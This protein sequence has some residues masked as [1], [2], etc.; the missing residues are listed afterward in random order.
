MCFSR[1]TQVDQETTI[2]VTHQVHRAQC[3]GSQVFPLWQKE[4]EQFRFQYNLIDLLTLLI[5][6]RQMN[7]VITL[8][9]N[10]RQ[11]LLFQ[12]QSWSTSDWWLHWALRRVVR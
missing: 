7:A 6:D 2:P 5:R 9:S 12:K 11:Y 10:K 1:A 4:R 8:R 3:R